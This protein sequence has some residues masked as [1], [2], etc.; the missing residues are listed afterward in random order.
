VLGRRSHPPRATAIGSSVVGVALLTLA[1]GVATSARADTNLGTVEGQTYISDSVSS[2]P[3]GLGA[4]VIADCPAKTHVIGGGLYQ[5]LGSQYNILTGIYPL[6]GPDADL[7]RDDRFAA[8][9]YSFTDSGNQHYVQAV[10][11]SGALPRYP[12]QDGTVVGEDSSASRTAL[13]PAGTYVSSGGVRMLSGSDASG[14][15]NSSYPFDGPDADT[16]PDDGWRVRVLNIGGGSVE[17]RAFAIC[18][19]SMPAYRASSEPLEPGRRFSAIMWCDS[20]GYGPVM[21]GGVRF[22][23]DASHQHFTTTTPQGAPG[24]PPS[25]GWVVTV[26]NALGGSPATTITKYAVCKP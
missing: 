9:I 12:T 18:R 3:A 14:E 2:V 20:Y 5:S 8:Q 16:M 7:A 6:D 15:V 13:C 1:L 11:A 22:T 19:D 26:A 23:G 10:C 4:T 21:G 17:F 24:E 25:D